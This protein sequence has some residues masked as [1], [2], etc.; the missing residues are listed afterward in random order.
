MNENLSVLK[1]SSR[2]FSSSIPQMDKKKTK[3]N[4]KSFRSRYPHLRQKPVEFIREPID[5]FKTFILGKA[6]NILSFTCLAYENGH[7]PNTSQS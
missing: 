3:L 7:E 5:S 1:H 4:F 2:S 6:I